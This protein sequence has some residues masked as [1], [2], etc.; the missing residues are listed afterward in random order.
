M[1]VSCGQGSKGKSAADG[2]VTVKWGS[3][4]SRAAVLNYITI[5]GAVGVNYSAISRSSKS[6]LAAGKAVK[7][8]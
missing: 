2:A 5:G 6:Q 1:S 3:A 8:N 7:V 4:V